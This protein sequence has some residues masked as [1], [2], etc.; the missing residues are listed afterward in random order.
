MSLIFK[1][2]P[3]ILNPKNY[4]FPS[5]MNTHKAINIV[6]IMPLAK[7]GQEI[8]LELPSESETF[9]LKQPQR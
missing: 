1:Q 7:D 5:Q 9:S 8:L 3:N 6:I 2:S 4:S